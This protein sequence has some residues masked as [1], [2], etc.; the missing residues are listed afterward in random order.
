MVYCDSFVYYTGYQSD[1]PL[2]GTFNDAISDEYH[3]VNGKVA[4][5]EMSN[6]CTAD[7]L[8]TVN[9]IKFNFYRL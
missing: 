6:S 5:L 4:K 7:K 9:M 8:Y 1:C 3:I 2:D